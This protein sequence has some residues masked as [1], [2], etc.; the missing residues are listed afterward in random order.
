MTKE[1]KAAFITMLI[2]LGIV[3]FGVGLCFIP[4]VMF[5]LIV[6]FF[7]SVL[8][9]GTYHMVLHEIKGEDIDYPMY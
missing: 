5:S 7:I 6:I 9:A 4:M 1:L 8:I 2:F 3:L